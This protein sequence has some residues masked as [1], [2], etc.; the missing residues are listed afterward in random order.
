MAIVYPSEHTPVFTPLVQEAGL[1]CA[2][3]YGVVWQYC[4]MQDKNCH[5]S[6]ETLGREIKV[7]KATMMRNIKTL[8]DLGYLI[9]QTPG[10]RNVPHT[11]ILGKSVAECNSSKETQANNTE[12][13]SVVI[14]NS[15]NQTVAECNP[16]VAYNNSLP[17]SV[18]QSNSQDQTVAESYLKKEESYL[19]GITPNKESKRES[20]KNH[21]RPIEIP[22]FK[23]FV[24]ITEYRAITKHWQGEMA[25]IVGDKPDDLAFW[26]KVVIGWT[27]KYPSK[28]NVEGMLDY[29]KRREIP[30][31]NG[32]RDNGAAR[33]ANKSSPPASDD[34][35]RLREQDKSQV[36]DPLA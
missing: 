10:L 32:N 7:N 22:S 23:I 15:S 6:L 19:T 30:G 33:P 1:V 34:Y 17:E 2:A 14:R 3:V 28:H 12:D 35:Q 29:Y 27:G 4:Q 5:A 16:T 25:R 18:A 13:T 9:D 24:E 36:F 8:C 31:Y 26:R 11:Y 21:T 20:V